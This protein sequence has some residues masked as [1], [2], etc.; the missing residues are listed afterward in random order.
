MKSPL[1]T[2]LR[3]QTPISR[4]AITYMTTEKYSLHI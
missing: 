3:K 4:K 1:K 2:G